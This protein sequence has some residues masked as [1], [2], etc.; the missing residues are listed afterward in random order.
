MRRHGRMG[1]LLLGHLRPLQHDR[2]R[3][4]AVEPTSRRHQPA[5]CAPARRPRQRHRQPVGPR[6]AVLPG[7]CACVAGMVAAEGHSA[8][9]RSTDRLTAAHCRPCRRLPPPPSL[10]ALQLSYQFIYAQRSGKLSSGPNPNPWRH[11]SHL[12]D[13]VVGGE[14][15]RRR[16]AAGGKGRQ[17]SPAGSRPLVSHS[18]P[19]LAGYYDAGDHLKL[20]FPLATS[21]AF[22]AWGAL[23]FPSGYATAGAAAAA[24]DSLKWGAAYLMAC[25]TSDNTFIAQIGNPGPGEWERVREREGGCA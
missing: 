11:D 13:P 8:R 15:R 1:R 7:A 21:L 18:L 20:N 6:R 2:A 10:Q 25:H 22:L 14:R 23:D 3:A 24:Q 19:P 12:A 16:K 5:A 17:R 4:A 9:R